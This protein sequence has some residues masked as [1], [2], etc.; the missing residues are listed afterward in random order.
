MTDEQNIR[1]VALQASLGFHENTGESDEV[2]IAFA[3]TCAKFITSGTLPEK[4]EDED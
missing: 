3:N 2:I 4:T 1:Q